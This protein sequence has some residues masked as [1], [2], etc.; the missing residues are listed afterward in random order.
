MDAL[1]FDL[2]N[3]CTELLPILGALALIFLCILLKKIWKAV[4]NVNDKITKLDPTVTKVNESMD[5]IQA[6]LD[7]AVK[8]S[9]SLDK[10][11]DKT[12]EVFGKAADFANDNIEKLQDAITD[13]MAGSEK[14]EA[15][16]PKEN[17]V[18][19]EKTEVSS[20]E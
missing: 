16:D 15:Q 12:A 5:K 8:Y 6:P 13:K 10:V 1:L 7:T 3:V 18:K 2:Q 20:H 14:E 11:H 17:T 19:K 4:D 9:H